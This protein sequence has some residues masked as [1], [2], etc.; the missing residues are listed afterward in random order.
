MHRC[1]T[2]FGRQRVRHRLELRISICQ[3]SLNFFRLYISGNPNK[4]KG[5][6][7]AR[8]QKQGQD[9]SIRRQQSLLAQGAGDARCPL[10]GREMLLGGSINEHHLVPRTH[11]GIAKVL[12][13]RVCHSKIHSV[14][15]ERELAEF[16]HTFDRLRSHPEIALFIKWVRRQPP[17]FNGKHDRPRR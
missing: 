14:F 3:S 15:N 8:R 10:C 6:S 2:D 17:E 5:M 7:P 12:M 4:I 13:H 16:Y 11:G 1:V 9:F